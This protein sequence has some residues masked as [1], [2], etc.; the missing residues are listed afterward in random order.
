MYHLREIFVL[1][2]KSQYKRTKNSRQYIS[3]KTC[4]YIT[5]VDTVGTTCNRQTH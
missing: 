1:L 3:A 4:N 2:L 5:K